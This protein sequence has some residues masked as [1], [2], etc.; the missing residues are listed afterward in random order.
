MY[1]LKPIPLSIP[2]RLLA[3][4]LAIGLPACLCACAGHPSPG[5]R[6]AAIPDLDS[7]NRV[8]E[9]NDS[10]ESNY[11]FYEDAFTAYKAE[12]LG[13]DKPAYMAVARGKDQDFCLFQPNPAHI[14]MDVGDKFKALGLEEPARDAYEAGLLSEGVNGD[15]LNIRLWSGMAQLHLGWGQTERSKRFLT[16]VLEVDNKN[17]WARKM[18]ASMTQEASEAVGAQKSAPAAKP[19]PGQSANR[20]GSKEKP[21]KAGTSRGRNYGMSTS[22]TP[23]REAAI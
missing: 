16:K 17:G 14:C 1:T 9:H 21:R 10:V 18:L 19:A 2:Y 5:W 20:R 8:V 6:S 3:W 15:A 23:V 13:V 4:S 7:L 11:F 12:F 22:A